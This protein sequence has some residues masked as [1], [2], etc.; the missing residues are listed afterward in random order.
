V[1]V[2]DDSVLS[3]FIEDTS[4]PSPLD[5][6]ITSDLRTKVA[7]VLSTLDPKAEMIIR[8]RFGI[9][10]DEQTLAVIAREFELSR[11]RIRQIE[12]AAIKKIRAQLFA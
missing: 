8:K 4:R 11:E 2:G 10:E 3:D 6:A 7:G 5:M 1:Q 12:V 9:A